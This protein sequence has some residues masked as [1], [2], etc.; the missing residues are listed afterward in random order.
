[1]RAEVPVHWIFHQHPRAEA[2][3][4]YR[5][6]HV[7]YI[8]DSMTNVP[9]EGEYLFAPYS[10]FTIRRVCWSDN[11]TAGNPHVVEL[12]VAVDNKEEPEDLLLAPWY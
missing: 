9:G 6:R 7:S 4:E 1:M 2:S 10:V 8:S 12:D 11:P 5:C 3:V